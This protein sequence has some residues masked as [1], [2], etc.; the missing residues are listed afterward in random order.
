MG[1]QAVSR[2]VDRALRIS[3]IDGVLFA[4]MLGVSE[5]YFGACAVALGH[6]DTALALLATL[7]LF[8]GALAQA[9]TGPL[10]LLFGSRKRL[11][12]C[13]ALLQAISH[14]GLI[15]VS[16]LSIQS[17]WLLLALVLLYYVSGM[18]IVPAWGAWM[19]ALTEHRD[20]ERY[21]ALRSTCVSLSMLG[22]FL[23]AGYRL[24]DAAAQHDV[25]HAYALLFAVGFIARL[26]SSCMLWKQPDPL[27][28]RRDSLRRVLAR[29]RSALK[30]DGFRLAAVLGLWMFGAHVSIPFYAPYMLKTLGLGYDGFALLCAVQLVAKTV[31]FPCTHRIAARLGLER[32][33]VASIAL[34]AIVAFIWGT[35]AGIA[36]LVLG[37]LL[38][39]GAWA[40]YEFA[41][42]QLLLRSARPSQRVE[43][44]A[45][46]AS[47]GGFMQLGGALLGSFLLSN[48]GLRYREVFLVSA[49]GRALPL[50]LLI[51]LVLERRTLA[52]VRVSLTRR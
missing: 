21:F 29:T 2:S 9:L 33:L 5:S 10:L 52:A 12:A 14:L 19:G 45:M 41:S 6:S 36:G 20:R 51:P 17:F 16:A 35:A 24:R 38:S 23:W 49:M 48:A 18:V 37:Q 47:F 43:F 22:A 8:A 42:F 26:C 28:V 1:S 32:M 13:G 34:A 40:C 44:L 27:P 30:S 15:V 31:A 25:A 46:S 7:P 11:V 3:L 39:G 50:L 4:L